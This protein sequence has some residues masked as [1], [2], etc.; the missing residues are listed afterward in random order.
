MGEGAMTSL[1]QA[2]AQ[3][4]LKIECADI[5]LDR[6]GEPPLSIH[7]PGTIFIDKQGQISFRFDVSS[8]QY[9]PFTKARFEHHRP[10]SA[11]PKDEDYYK[12][13]AT[14]ASE[15]VW[16]G[17]LLYPE[18]NNLT[19]EGFWN[20]PGIAEGKVHELNF[21]EPADP[22]SPSY[23]ELTIP[24]ELIIPRIQ[25]VEELSEPNY[26]YFDLGKEKI[27]IFVKGEYTEIHCLVKKDGIST[28][29]HWRMIEAIEFAIGQSIYPCGILVRENRKSIVTLISAV[30]GTE[31]EG[32]LLPPVNIS[33]RVHHF[34]IT[35]L[36]KKFYAYVLPYIEEFPPVIALGLRALRQAAIAQPDPKALVFSTTA[37]TLIHI[38]FP[39]IKPVDAAWKKEVEALQERLRNDQS[40]TPNLRERASNKLDALINEPNDEK[41]REFLRFH[42]RKKA[43]QDSVFKDW[44]DLRNPATHGKKIDPRKVD[45]A[46]RQISVVLDLCYSIVLCR[47][48]YLHERM[49]YANPYSDSWS[50]RALN[51]SEP[52]KPPL[53]S[54]TILS[55]F[56]WI[57]DKRRFRKTIPV[58]NDPK[59]SIELI[60]RSDKSGGQP[61]KIEVCPREIIPDDIA[62]VQIR[63]DYPTLL[64]AQRAC[65]EVAQRA[66]VHIAIAHFPGS[67]QSPCSIE[68]KAN[69]ELQCV[70][71]SVADLPWQDQAG[72]WSKEVP[73]PD[74]K[75]HLELTVAGRFKKDGTVSFKTE[76]HP[77]AVIPDSGMIHRLQIQHE[78]LSDAKSSCDEIADQI[79][80]L[81]ASRAAHS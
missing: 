28:N 36:V 48:G 66:L 74:T 41:I 76:V 43:E 27:E 67:A 33:G 15:Q 65:D 22:N 63:A 51:V 11:P 32:Q 18:V 9:K 37:E 31:N 42:I 53:G 73:I 69:N 40:L 4:I 56:N 54:L 8:E 62:E 49:S 46:F 50:I 77:T 38:C 20:G 47:I 34:P 13:T 71:M 10:P 68:M 80:Q 45:D 16:R 44:K 72:F 5:A 29:R 35:E 25:R 39:N 58:G 12:L 59:E 57:Q 2:A 61:F 70:Q 19:P 3:R 75:D 6:S 17:S 26:R 78:F 24:K 60:V 7:G 64:E 81:L 1:L 14:S 52:H 21:E 30:L 23:A 55:R 79:L